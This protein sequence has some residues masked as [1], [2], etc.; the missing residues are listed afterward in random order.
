MSFTIVIGLVGLIGVLFSALYFVM[1]EEINQAHIAMQGEVLNNLL[2]AAVDEAAMDVREQMN[3]HKGVQTGTFYGYFRSGAE[4]TAT[5]PTVDC[6]HTREMATKYYGIPDE[7]IHVTA[8]FINRRGFDVNMMGDKIKPDP[9]SIGVSGVLRIVAE[10]SYGQS[11][12]YTRRL[13]VRKDVKVVRVLPP[14]PDFA[15]AVLDAGYLHSEK[16]YANYN[17]WMSYEGSERLNFSVLAGD[18]ADASKNGKVLFAG[19]LNEDELVKM[20]PDPYPKNDKSLLGWLGGWVPS[21]TPAEIK[22]AGLQQMPIV[23]NIT[24]EGAHS[25]EVGTLFDNSVQSMPEYSGAAPTSDLWAFAGPG[26]KGPEALGKMHRAF[27]RAP[28]EVPKPPG[29][30]GK[31]TG[32]EEIEVYQGIIGYGME[33]MEPAHKVKPHGLFSKESP[34]YENYFRHYQERYAGTPFD[35][36]GSGMDLYG[37]HPLDER[38]HLRRVQGNTHVY[39]N[40]L[41]SFFQVRGLKIT[42]GKD[43]GAALPWLNLNQSGGA[44]QAKVLQDPPFKEMLQEEDLARVKW[45]GLDFKKYPNYG[46]KKEE[47]YEIPMPPGLLQPTNQQGLD[48]IWYRMLMTAPRYMPYDLEAAGGFLA[49]GSFGFRNF[50][51]NPI[52]LQ[53]Y[54]A[55]KFSY[56]NIPPELLEL[57]PDMAAYKFVGPMEFIMY[58]Q[59]LGYMVQDPKSGA[60]DLYLDGIWFVQGLISDFRY[61]TLT[62]PPPSYQGQPAGIMKIHGKGLIAT[63]EGTEVTVGGVIEAGDDKDTQ[64]SVVVAP[65]RILDNLQ[66]IARTNPDLIPMGMTLSGNINVTDQPAQLSLCSPLGGLKFKDDPTWDEGAAEKTWGRKTYNTTW[67]RINIKGNI[68]VNRFSQENLEDR[69]ATDGET[70]GGGILM[71]DDHLIEDAM[72]QTDTRNYHVSLGQRQAYYDITVI[73]GDPEDNEGRIE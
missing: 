7:D 68:A 54:D 50:Y 53:E 62:L 13:E 47:K 63:V 36:R 48:T 67:D 14:F 73:R 38:D 39:G 60:W 9:T 17:R 16:D 25:H 64:L 5:A 6:P 35:A 66:K 12:K 65:T 72:G 52:T 18:N 23:L 69:R 42:E 24:N 31:P 34:G 11:P 46:A 32:T 30:D 44:A 59:H 41:S 49:Q 57:S 71:Y 8:D 28:Y 2:E 58:L 45:K 27:L 20:F 26:E 61:Q 51:K 29:K 43:K 1:R 37:A 33:L 4:N 56:N 22:S 21:P 70:I 15:L 3:R 19:G 40:V 55:S 10:I